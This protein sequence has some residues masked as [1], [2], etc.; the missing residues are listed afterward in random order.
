MKIDDIGNI[1]LKCT[2]GS[3]FVSGILGE[4]IVK[5]DPIKIF[6]LKILKEFILRHN[7]FDDSARDRFNRMAITYAHV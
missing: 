2:E 5:N 6:D 3:V 7:D 4:I 1:W